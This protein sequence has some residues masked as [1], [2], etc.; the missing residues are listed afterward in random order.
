MELSENCLLWIKN[1]E[2]PDV[3]QYYWDKLS[4]E[5]QKYF[6]D[7]RE[8]TLGRQ[9]YI[10]TLEKEY[11]FFQ[12]AYNALPFPM[13]IKDEDAKFLSINKSYKTNA[14]VSF[15]DCS[16]KDIYDLDFFTQNEKHMLQAE[17]MHAI[18]QQTTLQKDFIFTNDAQKRK[19]VYWVSGFTTDRRE[20][21]VVA[22]YY[23]ITLFQNLLASLD[24]EIK[25]LEIEQKDILKHSSLDPLTGAYNRSVLN[26]FFEIALED[27]KNKNEEF[28]VLMLDIDHFKQV[29]D[30]YG[31]LVGDQVLQ[32]FVMLM[33]KTLRE[34]DKIIRF[35][36]EEFLILLSNT[37]FE[38]AYNI[39]ERIR[40]LAETNMFTPD[41]KPIT[42]SIGIATYNNEQSPEDLIKKA[43][44]NLYRAKAKGRNRVIPEL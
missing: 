37:K 23:D 38:F 9:K 14:Q 44:D 42:V 20:T 31:H 34:K 27:S 13:A 2:T 30:N 25:D 17:C 5:E 10:S 21:G 22:L 28:N 8:E 40:K 3:E 12:A 16:N 6:G 1:K 29:N 41:Q 33:K 18:K 39:A 15:D 43:D 7:I 35:G 19:F 24:N 26:H 4:E 36:G 11:R 32:L